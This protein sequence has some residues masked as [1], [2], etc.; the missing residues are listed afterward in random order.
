MFLAQNVRFTK[1]FSFCRKRFSR[2]PT[3]QDLL[4]EGGEEGAGLG[5]VVR[6]LPRLP[7]LFPV[8]RLQ[9]GVAQHRPALS[10]VSEFTSIFNSPLGHQPGR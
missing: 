10:P 1:M 2:R 4:E 5:Q 6:L 3:V 7:I 9:E 8:R